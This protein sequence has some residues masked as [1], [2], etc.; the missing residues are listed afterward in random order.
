MTQPLRAQE[1][2]PSLLVLSHIFNMERALMAGKNAIAFLI[3]ATLNHF[4]RATSSSCVRRSF[5]VTSS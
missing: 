1:A 2:R 3:I 4:C 5:L